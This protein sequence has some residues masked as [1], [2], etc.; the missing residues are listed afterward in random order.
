MTGFAASFKV[1]NSIK[2]VHVFLVA[3]QDGLVLYDVFTELLFT[4]LG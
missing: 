2:M 4:E 3:A 1:D